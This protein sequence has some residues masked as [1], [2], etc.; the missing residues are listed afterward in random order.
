MRALVL[1]MQM[2]PERFVAGPKGE[3]D[4]VFT[5]VDQATTEWILKHVWQPGVH[6][7]GRRTFDDMKSYWPTSTE[8]FAAPIN[9]IPRAVFT[10]KNVDPS[11]TPEVTA[12]LADATRAPEQRGEPTVFATPPPSATSWDEAMVASGT[13][14]DEIRELKQQ[15]AK[16]ILA[17]G[18]AGFAQNLVATGLIDEY[19]LIL[20]PVALGRGLPLF[21]VLSKPINLEL[22]E[23]TAFPCGS[24][25]QV[26]MPV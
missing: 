23:S 18:A 7:M 8:P 2:S 11:K 13:L 10:R 24:V 1:Q 17:H 12:A 9:E 25:A 5:T 22:A 20:H 14:A 15:S 4:W 19:R 3:L 21:S 16:A 6:I 26:Y